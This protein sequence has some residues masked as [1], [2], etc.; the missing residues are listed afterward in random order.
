MK[1]IIRRYRM[2]IRSLRSFV[3]LLIVSLLVVVAVGCQG[4]DEATAV[5]EQGVA[6]AADVATAT[7]AVVGDVETAVAAA[8]EA[9]VEMAVEA[10]V[11]A[12]IPSATATDV[13]TVTPTVTATATM[14]PS[15]SPSATATA[16]PA[17]TDT[18]MPTPTETAVPVPLPDWLSYLN[19]FRAMANLPPLSEREDYSEG[20]RLHSRYMVGNDEP[21]AHS[22]DSSK[23][24]F[25]R[26]GD[27]AA[28]NGNLFATSQ[29]EA[30][31]MWSVNFWVS[32]PFHLIGILNPNLEVV[33]YGDYVE[34]VGDTRMAGVMDIK[35]HPQ[36]AADAIEYPIIFPGDGSVTWLVR[37]SLFEWPSPYDGC[38]GYSAPSG[39][40]I[41][42]IL[43][44]GS[45]TPNVTG[46]SLT[47][48]DQLLDS[49]LFDETSFRNNNFGAQVKGREILDGSDAVVIM[50]KEPLPI[51]ETYT[52][53][54][55]VDGETYTW[56]F[57]TQKG[58]P[59][60]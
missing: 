15:P 6:S 53:Q 35:S 30:N 25:D 43:G 50:P 57:S 51:N 48:G 21:I 49:C 23:P 10:T 13:A 24:Y 4:G 26:R 20:S 5:S 9:T 52:V 56:D 42:L 31:Y 17:P 58:P 39:A 22:E 37:H 33:G 46:H 29:T 45:K 3:F 44:D 14:L 55:T 11:E 1:T 40:P 34:A 8:V 36:E 27:Q 19:R 7:E 60:Q 59:E 38:P 28:Q 54:V 2:L 16:T 12:A 41:V 47:K 18:P 32:S